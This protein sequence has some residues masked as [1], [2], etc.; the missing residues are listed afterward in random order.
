M[1]MNFVRTHLSTTPQNHQ[2]RSL[3]SSFA[4]TMT[5]QVGQKVTFIGVLHM[6]QRVVHSEWFVADSFNER[7]CGIERSLD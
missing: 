7:R 2:L 6:L 5:N 3:F 1:L 4:E